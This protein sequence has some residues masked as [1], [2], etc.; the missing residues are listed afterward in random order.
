KYTEVF[1]TLT[2]LLET[3]CYFRKSVRAIKMKQRMRRK[4]LVDVREKRNFVFCV[5][6]KDVAKSRTTTTGVRSPRQTTRREGRD[7]VV[8]FQ[9][10]KP[11]STGSR[12]NKRND[13]YRD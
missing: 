7:P 12:K 10:S 4:M 13:E 8:L 5:S 2:K 11:G 1:D 6:A 9:G 3:F